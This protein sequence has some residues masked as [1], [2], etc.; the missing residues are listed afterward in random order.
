MSGTPKRILDGVGHSERAGP[1]VP[2]G[3][4]EEERAKDKK[5]GGGRETGGTNGKELGLEEKRRREGR[6]GACVLSASLQSDESPAPPLPLLQVSRVYSSAACDTIRGP[7][8]DVKAVS[9]G[10]TAAYPH[11]P[12]RYTNKH[13]RTLSCWGRAQRATVRHHAP[14]NAKLGPEVYITRYFIS[15]IQQ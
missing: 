14:A 6:E 9:I 15:R 11:Y 12:S 7:R 1:S 4:P 5:G 10:A 3:T 2:R 13:G 8:M